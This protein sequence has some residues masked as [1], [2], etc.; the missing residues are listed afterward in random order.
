MDVLDFIK[1]GINKILGVE[2]SQSD[3]PFV[4]WHHRNQT[5]THCPLCVFNDGRIFENNNEKPL[6]GPDNHM[7]CECK[8][9]DVQQKSIGSISGK[10]ILSPDVYLSAYNKLPEYYISKDEAIEKYGWIQGKNTISGKAPGKMIGGDVFD[11]RNH[12]L[13]EKDGRIWYEC[14]VDYIEGK[15]NNKRLY[16]SNDGLMFYTESHNERNVV[17]VK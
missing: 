2:S 14:D 10:G 8:Y 17:Q 5:R 7:F 1:T 11:N 3:A 9:V 16:Y 6:I 4:Q 15:R 12:I 13:P